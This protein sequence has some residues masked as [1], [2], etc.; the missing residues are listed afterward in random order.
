[1]EPPDGDGRID[2][3]AASAFE[4]YMSGKIWPCASKAN[5]PSANVRGGVSPWP[6]LFKH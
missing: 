5:T 3:L 6:L 2:R 4:G 1:M